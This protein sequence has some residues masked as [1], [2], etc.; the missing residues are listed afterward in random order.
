MPTGNVVAGHPINAIDVLDE[1]EVADHG[2]TSTSTT[3]ANSISETAIATLPIAANDAA[4]GAVY[5]IRAWGTLAV[6]GTPTITFRGRLGG[7]GG[8]SMAALGAV[9]V[10][11]GAA[12]GQWDAEFRLAVATIGASGTWS[13]LLKVGHNFLTSATTYTQLGPATAAPVTR[14]STAANDMV[15]TAQWSAAS[16]S[17]TITCRGFEAKRVA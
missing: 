14:D 15:I 2:I 17:N 6:T 9:T 10:R 13:P 3:L 1:L 11:S 5:L 16:S 8:T 12:D 7:A 4:A